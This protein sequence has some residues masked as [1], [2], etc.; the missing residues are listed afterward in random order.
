MNTQGGE[1]ESIPRILFWSK[2][3]LI[4][5][6]ALNKERWLK[7]M[8]SFLSCALTRCDIYLAIS[9][10]N[11]GF[12]GFSSET[13]LCHKRSVLNRFHGAPNL[14]CTGFRDFS[15]RPILSTSSRVPVSG[16][17]ESPYRF[18]KSRSAHVELVISTTI[19]IWVY[20][21]MF[22]THNSQL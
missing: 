12:L 10:L 17:L 5:W 15:S 8:R 16:C 7:S 13:V 4:R 20:L 21:S 14:G 18:P 22:H 2:H 6:R 3:K 9:Y 1:R 19:N 11:S